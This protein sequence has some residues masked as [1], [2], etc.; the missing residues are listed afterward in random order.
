MTLNTT[1]AVRQIYR[2][3]LNRGACDAQRVGWNSPEVQQENYRV[4][5]D[6]M[7]TLLQRHREQNFTWRT[8]SIHDAGCGTGD[9]LDALQARGGVGCYLG[10]D[11]TPQSVELARQRHPERS[12]ARF[13]TFDLLNAPEA[14]FPNA[15]VT[16]C[17]GALAF[18][19]PRKV[20]EL[21]HRLWNSS[22]VGLGFIT[23]WNLTSDY[24]YFEHIEQLRKCVSRFLRKSKA[25]EVVQ[26][27]DYGDKTEAAFCLV[28]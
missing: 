9:L 21:L 28:K 15:D 7:E 19:P 27:H 11:F 6:A 2:N 22:Q 5:L 24:V 16:L 8:L 17:F 10:T 20:E 4:V 25:K 23:W 1:S 3:Y 14:H 12:D 26:Q 18:Y 13:A